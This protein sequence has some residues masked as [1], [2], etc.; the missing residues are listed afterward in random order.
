MI[1]TPKQSDAVNSI[2]NTDKV[3]TL[4][5]GVT[6]SGKTKVLLNLVDLALSLNKGTIF[7]M[8]EIALTSQFIEVFK[9]RYQN[10]VAVI[11]SGLSDKERFHNWKLIN[12]GKC[13]VV[14]GTR[15][16]VFAPVKNLGLII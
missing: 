8:P 14:L 9:S 16:A 15:S 10:D 13:K 3:T 1:L 11:H 6:G 12:E 7:M 5:Y 2:E 4:L